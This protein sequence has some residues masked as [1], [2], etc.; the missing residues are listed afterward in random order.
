MRS[1]SYL[2]QSDPARPPLRRRATAM[3]LTVAAH[4]LLLFL[5]LRLAPV[6]S[7]PPPGSAGLSTFDVLPGA[8]PAPKA[9][10][11]AKTASRPRA[12]NKPAVTPP[13]PRPV[14]DLPPPPPVEAPAM[15]KLFGDK[16]M[17]DAADIGKL[18]NHRDEAGGGASDGR[19]KDSVAVYGPGE[20]PGGKQLFNAEWER[21]PTRAEMAGYLPAG[22][23]PEGWAMVACQ[24]IPGNRV[25]NCRELGES[26]VGSKLARSLRQAAWQFHVRPPRVNGKPV[27]GAWVRIRFDWTTGLVR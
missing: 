2:S 25:E 6:L 27:I 18:P 8:Q 12:A 21:E 15:L 10:E 23:A 1:A 5:L 7:P 14:P 19:G 17:F 24:T 22:G 4:L 26:P 20:G 11:R 13:P 3:A 16:A 9:A